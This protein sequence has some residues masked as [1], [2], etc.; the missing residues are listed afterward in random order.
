MTQQ[1]TGGWL[2]GHLIRR[3]RKPTRCDYWRG[4]DNGGRCNA[5]IQPGDLYAE[6]DCTLDR[7]GGFGHHRY[8]LSCAGPEAQSCA[9]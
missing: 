8:C 9:R 6:G 2:D 4:L 1:I 7:A 3:A 5:P